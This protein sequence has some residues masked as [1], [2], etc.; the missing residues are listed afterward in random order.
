[1][2]LA[3]GNFPRHDPAI[4]FVD[5]GKGRADILTLVE[6]ATALAASG[7]LFRA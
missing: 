7:I 5:R 3:Q 2:P 4:L 6:A 1:M